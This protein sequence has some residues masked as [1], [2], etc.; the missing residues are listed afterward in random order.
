MAS[1]ATTATVTNTSCPVTK[2]LLSPRHTEHH[3]CLWATQMVALQMSIDNNSGCGGAVTLNTKRP[4]RPLAWWA[5]GHR[6]GPVIL[7]GNYGVPRNPQTND[8]VRAKGPASTA[9]VQDR[10]YTVIRGMGLG[11]RVTHGSHEKQPDANKL[12]QSLY[13]GLAPRTEGRPNHPPRCVP[14]TTTT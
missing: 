7:Q 1:T 2:G 9:T 12:N 13:V 14:P 8:V 5:G 10:F 3:M 11:F 4:P 6:W